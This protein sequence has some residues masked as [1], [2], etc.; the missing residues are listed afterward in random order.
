VNLGN[1]T[2]HLTETKSGSSRTVPLTREAVAVLR[3]APN[4]S[5]RPIDTDLVFF[6]EPGRDTVRRPYQFRPAR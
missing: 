4:N 3:L 6:G 5:V 2:D 1:R